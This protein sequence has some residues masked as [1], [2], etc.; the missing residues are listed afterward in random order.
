MLNVPSYVDIL[1][2]KYK[3]KIN[4]DSN[5]S[6]QHNKRGKI[7]SFWKC[8]HLNLYNKKESAVKLYIFSKINLDL[9]EK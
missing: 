9:R 6:K 8:Y 2:I 4:E 5:S 3:T 7:S 1:E